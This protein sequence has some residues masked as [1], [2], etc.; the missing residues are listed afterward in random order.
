MLEEFQG[1]DDESRAEIEAEMHEVRR[2]SE[3]LVELPEWDASQI[4]EQLQAE[5][6]EAWSRQAAA[7]E[8]LRDE[9]GRP[10][11]GERP[12]SKES[13]ESSR[14]SLSRSPVHTNSADRRP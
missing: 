9:Y 1:L 8:E 4:D 3:E 7:E 13:P 14:A 2:L 6:A 10:V 12:S 11:S 5:Q